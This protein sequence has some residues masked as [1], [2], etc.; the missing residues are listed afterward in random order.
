M[1]YI[2][3]RQSTS[4]SV[5]FVTRIFLKEQFYLDVEDALIIL[6]PVVTVRDLHL[7]SYPLTKRNRSENR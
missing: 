6:V 1:V 4:G 2:N 7:I 3:S 5:V